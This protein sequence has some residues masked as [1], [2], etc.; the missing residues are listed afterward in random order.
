MT[1]IHP[2]AIVDPAAELDTT[3]EVGPFVV[4]DGP[5]KIGAG[6]RLMAGAHVS[7]DTI[8]G[9]NNQIHMY[10]VLGHAPQHLEYKNAKSGL[11]IGDGNT[12][13]ECVTVHRAYHEG[14]FTV[15]GND[16]YFMANS[17]IAHDASVANRVIMANGA[18]LA[19]HTSVEDRAFISGNVTVHQYVAIGSLAM[20][21]GLSKVVK[22]VPPF[23]MV[24]G[25]SAI[26]G[27]NTVGLRRAGY[28][29]A[30]RE[31][32]KEAYKV[33]YRSGLS[34][35]NALKELEERLGNVPEIQQIL[36]FIRKSVRGIS[37]HTRRES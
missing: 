9:Q 5:V 34:V 15:I 12:F 19:G 1:Q 20:I 23:M 6:T 16:N 26:C 35:P 3:V 10:A 24:D 37:R 4:I 21:G 11:R 18:L 22:D 30:S 13:R 25:G 2:T 32:I 14:A 36:A 31:A 7:G 33:L 29:A 17:H 27:I 28:D 8:I